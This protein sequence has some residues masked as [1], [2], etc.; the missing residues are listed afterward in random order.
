MALWVKH[1]PADLEI[2]GL[3][4]AEGGNLFIIYVYK[5]FSSS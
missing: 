2:L 4:P 3:I 1:W 5:H